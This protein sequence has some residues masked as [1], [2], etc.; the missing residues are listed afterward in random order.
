MD[1]NK[2]RFNMVEQ[3]I[4]PWDVLDFDLLDA[5]ESIPRELFV[6]K[7]QQ[8]YA[9]ADLP[10]KLDNGST[11]LEPKIVARMVQGLTLSKTDRVMEIG[12]GSGYATAVLATLAGSVQ[13]YDVDEQQLSRAQA[14]LQSLNFDNIQFVAEDG[15]ANSQPEAKYDAIYVGGSLPEVPEQLKQQLADGG[16]LVVVVGGKPVQRCLQITRNG[17]EFSQKTLFDTLVTPLTTKA[18]KPSKFRF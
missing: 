7:E 10:L 9:Y 14:V 1:F 4:R 11:M 6:S 17:N 5:L 8:G 13:T 12:T 2:A 18:K 16:R 3:Q 15:F